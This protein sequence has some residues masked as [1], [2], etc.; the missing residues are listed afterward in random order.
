[1]RE[2]ILDPNVYPRKTEATTRQNTQYTKGN[3]RSSQRIPGK[4]QERRREIWGLVDHL[5]DKHLG[6]RAD[7]RDNSGNHIR[8][9]ST[10][11]RDDIL[12]TKVRHS[13]RAYPQQS[14]YS[15]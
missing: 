12:G 5:S 7:I 3:Q 9:L 8:V 14:E 11:D 15:G 13:P 1:M 10:Q 4:L 2:H 6:I